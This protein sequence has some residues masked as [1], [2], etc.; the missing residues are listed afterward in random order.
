MND[1]AIRLLSRVIAAELWRDEDGRER[2]LRPVSG[3]TESVPARQTVMDG[4]TEQK[5]KRTKRRQDKG[6]EA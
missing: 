3:R 1:Q 2:D 6:I 5:G 4:F